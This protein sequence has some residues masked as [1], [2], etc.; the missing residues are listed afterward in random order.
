MAIVVGFI[1]TA[2]GRAALD[3]GIVEAQR[4]SDRLL[5]IVHGTRGGDEAE[6]DR[7]VDEARD[8][9]EASGVGHDVRHLQRGSDVAEALMGAAEEASADLIVIGLRRRS[10][11]GKLILGSNAQR[12][13]LDASC[14]VLAVK[15]EQA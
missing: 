1:A 9:L 7:T 3:A 10:P 4:R 14:P 5:V 6:V 12:I 11:L 15:P 13:L 2:E 8:L